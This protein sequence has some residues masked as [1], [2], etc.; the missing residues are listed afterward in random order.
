[1]DRDA[2]FQTTRLAPSR[3]TKNGRRS[4]VSSVS[5]SVS[6]FLHRPCIVS[7]L[8]SWPGRPSLRGLVVSSKRQSR[9]LP[10]IGR[11]RRPCLPAGQAPARCVDP[12]SNQ[13]GTSHS[14]ERFFNSP[15]CQRVHGRA[16][17]PVPWHFHT[18]VRVSLSQQQVAASVFNT[19]SM[20]RS[21][22]GPK[23]GEPGKL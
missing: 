8:G 21:I 1:M 12:Q 18:F 14:T 20:E 3:I 6:I 5:Q 7:K 4:V 2:S 16:R 17:S 15:A 19:G 22:D 9:S 11:A 23:H 13:I 10:S